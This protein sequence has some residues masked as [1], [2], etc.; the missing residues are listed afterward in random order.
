MIYWREHYVT[1]SRKVSETLLIGVKTLDYCEVEN[2]L[3]I[4][5]S[6][7]EVQFAARAIHST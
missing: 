4:V 7:R 2:F 5:V 1:R 3:I 6:G